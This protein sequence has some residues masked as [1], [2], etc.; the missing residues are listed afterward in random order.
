MWNVKGKEYYDDK[1][2][3][4]GEYLYSHKYKGKSYL[5]GKIEFEGEYLYDKN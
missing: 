3:F 5:K 1:L 2:L 4:E